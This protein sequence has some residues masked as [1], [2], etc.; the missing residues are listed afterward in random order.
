MFAL[1]AGLAA[2]PRVTWDRV[3]GLLLSQ[4]VYV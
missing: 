3:P 2:D 4:T 1:V